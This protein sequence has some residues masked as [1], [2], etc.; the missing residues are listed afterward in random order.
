[1]R[2]PDAERVDERRGI[3]RHVGDEIRRLHRHVQQELQG[4]E[5]DAR[6]AEVIELRGEAG[7]AVVEAHDAKAF[8]GQHL[9]ERVGP[10]DHLHAEAHHQQDH[11][12]GGV[13]ERLVFERYPV[14]LDRGHGTDR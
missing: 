1:M 6:H 12:I 13:A 5:A 3:A 11:G 7:I 14:S 9:A 2:A 4:L 10:Q 8:R